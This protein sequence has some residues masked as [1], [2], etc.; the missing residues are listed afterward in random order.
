MLA[1]RPILILDE[2]TSNVDTRARVA[3]P[4]R[5]GQADGRP[6]ELRDRAPAL[7]HQERGHDPVL[8]DGDVVE[9]GTHEDLLASGGFYAQLYQS[10]FEEVA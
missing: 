7:Y 8:R 4:A 3:H 6:H 2:A 10:Q 9:R 1:D 5:H